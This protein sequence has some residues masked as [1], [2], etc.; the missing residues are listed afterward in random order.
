LT[1][2]IDSFFRLYPSSFFAW[3]AS[4]VGRAADS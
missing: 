1:G 3:A 4:S 2:E